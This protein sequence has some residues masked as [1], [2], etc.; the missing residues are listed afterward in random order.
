MSRPS[1]G[2]LLRPPGASGDDGA[3][4]ERLDARGEVAVSPYRDAGFN[5][6]D[7]GT[8]ARG[9][10]GHRVHRFNLRNSVVLGIN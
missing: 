9:V 4:G 7:P 3:H 5:T 2:Q 10:R 1:S 6:V 8:I